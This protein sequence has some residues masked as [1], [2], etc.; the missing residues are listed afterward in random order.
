M[1]ACI[2]GVSQTSTP[3]VSWNHDFLTHAAVAKR[4][5]E[6]DRDGDGFIT[7]TECRAA[8][9]RLEN[10]LSDGQVR[11]SLWAWDGTNDNERVDY[12]EFMEHFVAN[13]AQDQADSSQEPEK[14][15]DSIDQLLQHCVVKEDTSVAA[16]L[17]RDAKTELIKQFKLIDLDN[18]GYLDRYE[19]T[20]ALKAMN[21][22]MS[23]RAIEFTLQNFFDVADKNSDGL[24]DL[25]EFSTRIVQQGLYS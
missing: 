23:S 16:R 13:P 5:E 8:I 3:A 22:D 10:E 9:E 6:F 2:A 7:L 12:F 21:P 20:T 11:E 15:F 19:L 4:F 17:S 14:K 25:Y 24:I 1:K 18:D